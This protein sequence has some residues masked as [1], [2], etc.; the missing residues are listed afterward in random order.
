MANKFLILGVNNTG[1]GSLTWPEDFHLVGI[2]DDQDEA[3]KECD[4][5]NG[6]EEDSPFHRL[7]EPEDEKEGMVYEVR[8]LSHQPKAVKTR[9]R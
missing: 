7:D 9:R 4:R 1:S 8:T 3:E 2:W 5:L 6:V